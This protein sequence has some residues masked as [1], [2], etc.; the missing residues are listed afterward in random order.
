[1]F[2]EALATILARL[3][4][5]RT[6]GLLQ[7]YALIGGFAV[8][9]WGVPRATQDIDFAVAIG[10]TTPQALA[11]FLGGRYEAGE[12]DDP[13]TGVL[14]ASFE[15]GN[16]PVPLQLI[17]LP[18]IF[19]KVTFQQVEWLPVMDRTVPVVSWQT[20]VLLKIYAGGPQDVLDARQI[21]T[22]RHPQPDDLHQITEM[23]KSLGILEEWTTFLRCHPQGD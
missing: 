10:S 11:A 6:D 16:E 15:G 21:L 4:S 20:L 13:L 1:V 19:T 9:A 12:A 8:S 17:F 23:A 3:E 22:M 7:A 18:P 14:H 5:A 2:Q